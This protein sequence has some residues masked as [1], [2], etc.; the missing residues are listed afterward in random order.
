MVYGISSLTAAEASPEQLLAF[1]RGHW[2]IE[3]GL[4]YRRDE[5]L[6]EDWCHL[7]CGNAPRAMAVINNLIIGLVLHLKRKNLPA[8]RRYFDSHPQ[9]AQGLV[10]RRLS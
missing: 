5:T 8:T 9:E 10:L 4:H 2:A 7:K 3:N 6:R 1:N